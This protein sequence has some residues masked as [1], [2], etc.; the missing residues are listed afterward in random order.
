LAAGARHYVFPKWFI[1]G[2]FAVA[3]GG[4][5]AL[6]RGVRAYSSCSSAATPGG[7]R[8]LVAAHLRDPFAFLF[9]VLGC[10]L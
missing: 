7:R 9:L 1:L 3:S 6:E 2:G 5:S 4:G 8:R 10:V